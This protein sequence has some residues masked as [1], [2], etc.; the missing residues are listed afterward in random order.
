MYFQA[1]P[2]S[3]DATGCAP[4]RTDGNNALRALVPLL[5]KSLPS[6]SVYNIHVYYMILYSVLT[7]ERQAEQLYVRK[8][9]KYIQ[10]TFMSINVFAISHCIR[11]IA[12]HAWWQ[13]DKVPNRVLTIEKSNMTRLLQHYE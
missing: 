11:Y 9:H 2:F 5:F 1:V 13:Y 6:L 12:R 4:P 7:T 8:I 10:I 3:A